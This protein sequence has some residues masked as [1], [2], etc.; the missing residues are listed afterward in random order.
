MAETTPTPQRPL[1]LAYICG[2]LKRYPLTIGEH[3]VGR[4]AGCQ[5]HLPGRR[6]SKKHAVVVVDEEGVLV[7]DM[8]SRNGVRVNNHRVKECRV[9]DGDVIRIGSFDLLVSAAPDPR[10]AAKI[11]PPPRP[12]FFA[13][14][15]AGLRSLWASDRASTAPTDSTEQSE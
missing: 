1:R 6:V 15:V 7:R 9:S 11:L 12:G 3:V 2:A 8:D 5:V 10:E 14:L 13:S 4:A